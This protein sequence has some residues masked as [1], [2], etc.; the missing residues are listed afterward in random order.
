MK[1]LF[2]NSIIKITIYIEVYQESN[3]DSLYTN[4]EVSNES[5]HFNDTYPNPVQIKE[6][7]VILDEKNS[8][9]VNI[10]ETYNDPLTDSVVSYTY[11]K[12]D[13]NHYARVPKGIYNK[14]ALVTQFTHSDSSL[15]NISKV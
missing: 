1:N 9:E 11:G 5:Q 12:A 8:S 4:S 15:S 13:P 7:M 10:T 3:V 6:E 14:L 2:E